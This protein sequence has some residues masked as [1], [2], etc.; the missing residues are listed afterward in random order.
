M[1]VALDLDLDLDLM[2]GE[3]PAT[4]CESPHHGHSDVHQGDGTHYATA[5]HECFGPVGPVFAVCEAY[6][7]YWQ[8]R[9]GINFCHW[10]RTRITEDEYVEIIGAINL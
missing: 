9:D 8:S 2:V 6:A 3:M 4:P 7:L 5:G 1:S 10:C